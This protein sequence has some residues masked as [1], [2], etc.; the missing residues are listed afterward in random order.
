MSSI[1]QISIILWRKRDKYNVKEVSFVLQ[2]S[3]LLPVNRFKQEADKWV[4]DSKPKL[5]FCVLIRE[6]INSNVRK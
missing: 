2:Q 5:S 3:V 4:M 1:T 6:R